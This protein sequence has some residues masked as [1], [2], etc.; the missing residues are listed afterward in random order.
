MVQIHPMEELMNEEMNTPMSPEPA[1]VTGWI[2]TWIQAVTKPNEQ[3]FMSIAASSNAKT[4][5]ALLWV[6]M[7]SLVNFFVVYL[8]Q[9]ASVKTMMSEFGVTG[10]RAGFSLV[11]AICGAP[12]AAVVSV[13]GFVV[14]TGIVQWVA[15]MFGG[16]GTFEKLA[17]TLAAITFPVSLASAFL[18]LLAA[19][20][21]IGLCFSIL[22]IGLG[23]YAI[24]L[25][26]MAVKV[27]NM[28]GYGAAI[29]SILV[30]ALVIGLIC[31]CVF[32][33]G[34]IG[35]MRLLGPQIGNTFSSINNSLP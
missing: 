16:T 24:I 28:F 9:S 19:I 10:S 5:T 15:K 30:P 23:I 21:Y 11:T 34:T 25:E 6:F 12:V 17:Y 1:G 8:V 31:G 3:T 22:S 29:G 32:G 14:F 18:A 20:P 26:V 33:L 13:L 35:L 4:S 2:E 27:V 7:G